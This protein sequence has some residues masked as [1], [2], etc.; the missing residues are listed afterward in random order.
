MTTLVYSQSGGAGLVGAG[1]GMIS[2]S[3]I[4][5]SLLPS[6]CMIMVPGGSMGGMK[7]LMFGELGGGVCGIGI[8]GG[9]LGGVNGDASMSCVR[10]LLPARSA[11][12]CTLMA[13]RCTMCNATP[14]QARMARTQTRWSSSSGWRHP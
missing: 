2:P 9:V 7:E 8:E 3:I 6:S 14:A 12:W 1:P 11:T 4:V 10:C 13:T 5:V